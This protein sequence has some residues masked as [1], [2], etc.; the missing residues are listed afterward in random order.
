MERK[1]AAGNPSVCVSSVQTALGPHGHHL[2]LSF[3]CPFFSGVQSLNQ[4]CPLHFLGKY[5][6]DGGALLLVVNRNHFAFFSQHSC[7]CSPIW[8]LKPEPFFLK[9]LQEL[10]GW[11][12]P[13]WKGAAMLQPVLLEAL[14]AAGA[15]W[16]V[17][18]AGDYLWS[19]PLLGQVLDPPRN[20]SQF[21]VKRH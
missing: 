20:N 7:L 15:L 21:P 18:G 17:T 8:S 6:K 9:L 16:H 5:S 2:T 19:C 13:F 4:G 12:M 14:C 3:T 11:K 1:L 10:W